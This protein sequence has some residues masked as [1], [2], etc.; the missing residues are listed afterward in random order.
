MYTHIGLGIVALA[1]IFTIPISDE[2]VDD[3]SHV[4]GFVTLALHDAAG[5]AIFE[6]IIHNQLVNKG[7]DYMLAQSF[8]NGTDG[9]GFQ[10]QEVDLI[11][12]PK[13]VV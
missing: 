7:E 2:S 12:Y 13:E 10:D 4:Y 11:E 9:A 3:S 1:V 8:N 5:N 6:Q